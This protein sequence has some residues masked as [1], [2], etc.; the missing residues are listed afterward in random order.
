M[1]DDIVKNIDYWFSSDKYSLPPDSDFYLGAVDNTFLKKFDSFINEDSSD[2]KNT[3]FYA[4]APPYE[5]VGVYD[6]AYVVKTK[7]NDIT[8]SIIDGNLL[9]VNLNQLYGDEDK[10]VATA[11]KNDMSAQSHNYPNKSLTA[12]SVFI[13]LIGLN[14]PSFDKTAT[15]INVLKSHVEMKLATLNE[16]Q[17]DTA[18]KYVISENLSLNSQM[19]FVKIGN[20]WHY[21][22]DYTEDGDTISFSWLVEPATQNL[23][24]VEKED[25]GKIADT[26]ERISEDTDG[27]IHLV[28]DKDNC[29]AVNTKSHFAYLADDDATW[30]SIKK[31]GGDSTNENS[32]QNLAQ[33]D[34][35]GRYA[36]VGYIK[37]DGQWINLSKALLTAATNNYSDS[38]YNGSLKNVIN[39]KSYDQDKVEFADSYFKAQ[40]VLDDRRIIQ[41]NIFGRDFSN[42]DLNEWT[43]TLGDITLFVPPVNITFY[44][45]NESERMPLLRASGSME[46]QKRRSTRHLQLTIYFNDDKG[47]NGYQYNTSTPSGEN[48]TY[49]LNGLRALFS[50]FKFMPFIPI[51]NKYI[52]ETLDIW[53]VT[54]NNLSCNNVQ[55][56]PKLIQATLTLTEFDYC[57]YMP[58]A[59][60]NYGLYVSDEGNPFSASINWQVARYYYQRPLI[61]GNDLQDKQL[62]FNSNN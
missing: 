62:D 8:N 55:G 31:M 36:A 43:V 38:S 5:E 42:D 58:E 22:D 6:D 39:S 30:A 17:N 56:Y 1:S 13:N 51:E 29:S 10:Q 12:D 54:V 61:A 46:K 3:A 19:R 26:L 11:V 60:L 32:A 28:L 50:Q 2:G 23:N 21:V 40:S 24:D 48:I 49:H 44:S 34:A 33:T 47:I 7:I 57:V 20:N 53:T 9:R 45:E 15:E 41:K 52:N 18:N 14:P 59:A 25:R 35:L 16:I 27:E 4:E 37:K